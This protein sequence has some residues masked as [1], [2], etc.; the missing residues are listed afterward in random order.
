LQ[1]NAEG[2]KAERMPSSSEKGEGNT[3]AKMPCCQVFEPMV[4]S[5]HRLASLGFSAFSEHAHRNQGRLPFSK[6]LGQRILP[7][8]NMAGATPPAAI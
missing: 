3:P 7:I 1:A 8:T 6:L 2:K 4:Q 5:G